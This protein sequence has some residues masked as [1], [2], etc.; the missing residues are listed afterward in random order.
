M[1]LQIE[2]S[3]NDDYIPQSETF[4]WVKQIHTLGPTGTNCERAA[5]SWALRRCHGASVKLHRTMEQAAESVACQDGAVLVG[6]VA[7][8]HLH[9]IIYAHIQKMKLLDVFIMN[10][11]NMVLASRTG[12]E[13]MTCATHP[14]PEKLLPATVERRFVSSNV[15]AARDCA[16][17]NVDGCITTLCAAEKFGLS[18][19][20]KFG[21]VPMGFTIH[22]PLEKRACQ[23]CT[24]HA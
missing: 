11:D 23:D 13:P 7:Y 14:A 9:S 12:A 2:N 4:G 24:Q 17:G 16:A 3:I 15:I 5:I 20:R 8:P 6:V 22:G 1:D 10:T 19:L 18:I 21:P